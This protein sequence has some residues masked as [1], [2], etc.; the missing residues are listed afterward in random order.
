M[1]IPTVY[2]CAHISSKGSSLGLPKTT[3][4]QAVR[5][6]LVPVTPSSPGTSHVY[7]DRVCMCIVGC[8]D[9]RWQSGVRQDSEVRPTSIVSTVEC[10]E[11][12]V[13]PQP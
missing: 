12:R 3:A 1:R 2:A 11:S 5:P 10:P 7:S 6:R 8:G 13:L 4:C 9:G